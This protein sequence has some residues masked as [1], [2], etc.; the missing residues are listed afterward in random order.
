MKKFFI[1]A[2]VLCTLAL[3]S[4]KCQQGRVQYVWHGLDPVYEKSPAPI[5]DARGPLGYPSAPR[6]ELYEGFWYGNNNFSNFGFQQ[7]LYGYNN[8]N[9]AQFGRVQYVWHGVDPVYQQNPASIYDARGPLGFVSPPRFELYDNYWYGN[10]GFNNFSFFNGQ[11]RLPST[12]T[13]ILSGVAT[14]VSTAAQLSYFNDLQRPVTYQ[15]NTGTRFP[16][17]FTIPRFSN[18]W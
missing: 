1:S 13:M 3:Q 4:A 6:P 16:A 9:N 17:Q 12:G 15:Y 14:G 5:Y 11:Y 8:F 10:N 2:I 7:Q 18:R